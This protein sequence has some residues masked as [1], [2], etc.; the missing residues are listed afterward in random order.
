MRFK[1]PCPPGRVKAGLCPPIKKRS[2]VSTLSL[3]LA[4][5][6]ARRGRHRQPSHIT[7]IR[8]Q[9]GDSSRGGYCD[10]GSSHQTPTW[11]SQLSQPVHQRIYLFISDFPLFSRFST[12]FHPCTRQ[13]NCGRRIFHKNATWSRVGFSFTLFFLLALSA[14]MSNFL[15][16]QKRG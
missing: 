6:T 5:R 7:E 10:R 2:C 15:W 12:L 1:L 9:R 8:S 4:P 14:I 11:L 13:P 3:T 16:T